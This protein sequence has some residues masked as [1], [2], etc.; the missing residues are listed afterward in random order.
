MKYPKPNDIS[1]KIII[2]SFI[3]EKSII[4]VFGNYGKRKLGRGVFNNLRDIDFYLSRLDD[5]KRKSDIK[6]G[7]PEIEKNI[8]KFIRNRIKYDREKPFPTYSL[9]KNQGNCVAQTA[10]AITMIDEF[11]NLEDYTLIYSKE[12]SIL[13]EPTIINPH[14][15]LAKEKEDYYIVMDTTKKMERVEKGEMKSDILKHIEFREPESIARA[16]V[17]EGESVAGKIICDSLKHE[18]GYLEP[19]EYKRHIDRLFPTNR[20]LNHLNIETEAPLQNL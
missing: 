2:G 19:E 13:F 10:L 12:L 18:R 17:D 1:E 5:L 4:D 20:I 6:A 14:V 11:D 15:R 7:S 9:Q 3:C 16:I 8:Y